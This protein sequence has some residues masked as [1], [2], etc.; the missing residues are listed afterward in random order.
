MCQLKSM[1]IRAERSTRIIFI[2]ETKVKTGPRLFHFTYN[3]IE[4][5]PMLNGSCDD[6]SYYYLLLLLLLLSVN[7]CIYSFQ[8]CAC[9]GS[10]RCVLFD[11]FFLSL[12]L[13]F[14]IL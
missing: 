5:I 14:T 10:M 6:Y 11:F 2:R 7:V 4:S 8:S 9:Y 3:S 1:E 12:Y 13:L